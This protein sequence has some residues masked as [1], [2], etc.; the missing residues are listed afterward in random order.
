M[1]DKFHSYFNSSS[2]EEKYHKK[3]IEKDVD[4]I[5]IVALRNYKKSTRRDYFK[6]DLFKYKS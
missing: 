3:D 5:F 4:D 2:N 6:N 1:K